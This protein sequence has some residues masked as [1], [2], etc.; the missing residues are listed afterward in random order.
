MPLGP[1]AAAA[2]ETRARANRACALA[3]A[4][5]EPIK[6]PPPAGGKQVAFRIVRNIVTHALDYDARVLSSG[7]V[8]PHARLIENQCWDVMDRIA[9]QPL[10][11]VQRKQVEL[12]TSLGGLQ[13]PMP[14]SL[15]PMARAAGLMESGPGVRAAIGGW[16]YDV[17]TAFATDGVDEALSDGLLDNL[18]EQGISVGPCGVPLPLATAGAQ[19]AAALRPPVPHQ[20][21][22]SQML[23]TAAQHSYDQLFEGMGLGDRTRILSAGG[24]T[25]GKCLTAAA[26]LTQAHFSDTTFAQII[27]WRLG[28]QTDSVPQGCRNAKATGE[29]CEASLDDDHA[30]TCEWGPLWTQKHDNLADQL[31]ECVAETG[32]HVRREAWIAELATPSAEAILDIWA[33]GAVNVPDSLVDVTI[34]HPRAERYQPAAAMHAGAAASAAAAEKRDRYPARGGREVTPF[35]VETWGRLDTAAETFLED[36]AAAASRHDALRGRAPSQSG[37]LKRWRAAIDAVV[38]RGVALS[39][40]AARYG[41]PGRPPSR[42]ARRTVAA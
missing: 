38:Q 27:R 12:P 13:M 26:G 15:V 37:C 7:L 10:T 30:A 20:H 8:L 24:P 17:E 41:L 16:G 39:L 42:I 4:A 5:K 35:A 6:R 33:F 23:R 32:A 1:L 22:L 28:L 11:L 29:I 31:A 36:M 40:H 34:R 3:E 18:K 25:A 14:T 2:V 9:G 19:T 21:L